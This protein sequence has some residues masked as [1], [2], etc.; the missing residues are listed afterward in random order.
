MVGTPLNECANRLPF[1]SDIHHVVFFGENLF[2][3]WLV[4]EAL[5]RHG[6][7]KMAEVG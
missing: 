3:T 7:V 6:L 4:R 5:C 1:Q 2:D